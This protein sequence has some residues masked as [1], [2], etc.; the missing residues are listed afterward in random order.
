[1]LSKSVTE[2]YFK[3]LTINNLRTVIDIN[4]FSDYW[5]NAEYMEQLFKI[6]YLNIS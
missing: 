1:M 4:K 6:L 2:R 3:K 5:K